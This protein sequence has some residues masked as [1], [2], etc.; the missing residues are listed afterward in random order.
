MM[1]LERY[2]DRAKGFIQSAQTLAVRD[3]HQQF[4]PEHIF[5]ELVADAQGMAANLVREAGG[6]WDGVKDKVAAALEKLPKIESSAPSGLHLTREAAKFFSTAE[7]V[8]DKAKDQF[9]TTEMM[10]LALAIEPGT[11]SHQILQ[12]AGITPQNLNAA[13]KKMRKGRKAGSANAEDSYE[14][15]EK[16]T[17][18]FTELAAEGKLDPVIGRDE[19]IRRTMQ[20]LSRRTK[21]NPVL[22]GEPG[23]GENGDH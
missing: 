15:L 1:Q 2:T 10:L 21:N 5:R 4:T 8:A 19:E 12:E 13:I 20:V 23:V 17:K 18:N 9:V 16:Y 14:A 7:E 3:G 11:P 6:Q 22:I